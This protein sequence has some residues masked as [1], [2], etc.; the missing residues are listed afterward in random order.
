MSGS[1]CRA[2]NHV[3]DKGRQSRAVSGQDH[4]DQ[5]CN[6]ER[7]D[8]LDDIHV[9]GTGK[10]LSHEHGAA[11]RRS[12]ET[13][14]QV[15]QDDGTEVDGINAH[16]NSGGQQQG[17]DQQDCGVDVDQHAA[18]QEQDVGEDQEAERAGD[19]GGDESLD[20]LSNADHGNDTAGAVGEADQDADGSGADSSVDSHVHE[21]LIHIVLVHRALDKVEDDAVQHGSRASLGSGKD[22]TVDAAEDDDGHDQCGDR[23]DKGLTDIASVGGE[24]E[25]GGFFLLTAALTE[26]VDEHEKDDAADSRANGAQP[27][28]GDADACAQA[29]HDAGDRRGDQ[30]A[31]EAGS[32]GQCGAVSVRVAFLLHLGDHDTADAADGSHA[33]TSQDAECS[34]GQDGDSAQRATQT[35]HDGLDQVNQSMGNAAVLHD[36]T[37]EDEQR[38]SQQR[39]AVQT[40][41]RDGA[42]GG[43]LHAGGHDDSQRGG[44]DGVSDRNFAEHR[45]TNEEQ[46]E[47]A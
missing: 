37:G 16:C 35:A 44:T 6:N 26:V 28:S 31:Q 24:N 45:Q 15:D 7:H 23:A 29:I 8:F 32:G 2:G 25:R 14:A 3:G 34:G 33:G 41:E 11:E 12:D 21:R 18:D 39:E 38:H 47:D 40:G 9:A 13:N 4:D 36:G 20:G 10:L 27:D 46:Q 1:G 30:D 42:D 5:T 17:H 43:G 22:T 19:V